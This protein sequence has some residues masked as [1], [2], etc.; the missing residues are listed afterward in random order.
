MEILRSM[1]ILLLIILVIVIGN[2]VVF[3]DDYAVITGS[4]T[5]EGSS[6]PGQSYQQ[7]I[8]QIPYPT[9]YNNTNCVC[10]SFGTTRNSKENQYKYDGSE[11]IA[12]SSSSLV[13]GNIPKGL[14]LNSDNIVVHA[15]NIAES[16]LTIYYKIV[17]MKIS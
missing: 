14:Y 15:Y 10:V 11:G 16:S 3:K 12:S 17:L 4:L 6:N 7:S 2:K 8:K 5:A 1:G 9:G 13:S